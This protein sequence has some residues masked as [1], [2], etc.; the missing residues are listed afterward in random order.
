MHVLIAD[1]DPVICTALQHVVTDLG[2]FAATIRTA[3]DA[4]ERAA[5]G[6]FDVVLLDLRFP[7]CS[8]LSTLREIRRR[9]PGTDVVVVSAV[10]DDLDMVSEAVDLGAFDYLPKPLREFDVRIALTRVLRHRE[11]ARSNERLLSELASGRECSDIIG[12]SLAARTLRRQ[13][14]D[15]AGHDMPVLI[16]G[17]TG[18]GKELVARA[19]HYGGDRRARPFVTVNC[20]ALPGELTESILFGH[21][22]GAFTGASVEHEGAFGEAGDG[23]LFLDEIGDLSGAAPAALLRVLDTGEY[24]PVGGKTR[25]SSARLVLATNRDLG[26]LVGDGGF[27]KDLYY[28][29][30]RLRI[31]TPPLRERREDVELLAMHFLGLIDRKVGKGISAIDPEA[32]ACLRRYD[33]PGNVRELRNEVE[34]AYINSQAD[35]LDVLDLASELLAGAGDG[36]GP[37]SLSPKAAEE[38]S[39]LR[40]ALR[41]TGGRVAQAARL[42]G[43]HRNTVHRWMRRLGVSKEGVPARSS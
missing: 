24:R 21:E 8:D 4:V 18:T 7:D 39:R 25:K 33:W 30:D 6:S 34:R 41:E 23:T 3:A 17:E 42:L 35:T 43:V 16:T 28:R 5:S 15:Q 12:E 29:I 37:D 36:H 9:S 40:G 32:L 19:I 38:I 26:S 31:H 2:H 1:D 22:K 10:T 14:A 11:L 20:C 27:R 13:V